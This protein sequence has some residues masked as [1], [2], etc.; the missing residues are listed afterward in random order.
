MPATLLSD[1]IRRLD[2][3]RDHQE[4]VF[5]LSYHVFPWDSERS[6]EFALFRTFAVPSISTLLARTG[7]FEQ[8]PR[9]RYDDTELILAEIF[10]NGYDSPRARRAFRRMNRMHGHYDIS[11]D[12]LLYVLSTFV[13]EP[14]RWN[15]RFG[16]RPLTENEKLATFLFFREIGRRMGIRD[17]PDTYGAFEAFNRDYET[18]HFRYAETNRRTG[19][20]TLN[21]LLGFYLPRWLWPL[22]RPVAYALMDDPLLQAMGFPPPP[23]LIKKLVLGGM[24]LRARLLRYLPER[25]QPRLITARRRKTYPEG[26]R[27]E[28][29]GTFPNKE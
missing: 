10:E 22:G 16:R 14:I 26:Y 8:R 19:E 28:E 27:I 5:L 7:E 23:P 3:H 9:K 4:I 25:R 13:F 29:L 15:A 17:I 1:R 18:R 12:D 6:L 21:L 11:N 20:A 2:P 24:K